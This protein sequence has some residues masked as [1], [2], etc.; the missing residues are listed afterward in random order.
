[1]KKGDYLFSKN[2]LTILKKLITLKHPIKITLF[3]KN[4]KI[5]HKTVKS[6]VE[7]LSIINL[8]NITINGRM[9]LIEINKDNIEFSNKFISLCAQL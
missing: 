4:I 5:A 7:F 2:D 9:K 6:R 3:S 8:V 1:M